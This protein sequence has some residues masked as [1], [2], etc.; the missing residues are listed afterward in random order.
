M[1]LVQLAE[2]LRPFIEKAVQSLSDA[3]ASSAPQLFPTLKQ[4]GALVRAGT[5]I[6][7]EN[8]IMVAAVDL[9][10]TEPNDPD[11]APALWEKIMYRDGIRIIPETITVTSMFSEDER[12]WWGDDIYESKVNNNVY[13]P[14]QYPPNWRLI[15]GG[16]NA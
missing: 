10:D 13:T 16:G 15:S 14:A 3:D 5:R 7:W 12:G 4:D 11:H 8:M 1:T 2:K 6:N 9:W